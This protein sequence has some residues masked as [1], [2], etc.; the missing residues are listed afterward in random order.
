M[1]RHVA[2]HPRPR[3]LLALLL[4]KLLELRLM[5]RRE[6]WRL[7][8]LHARLLSRLPQRLLGLL[9]IALDHLR[10]LQKLLVLPA[11]LSA[12]LALTIR[13][14]C[15]LTCALGG[16]IN[17]PLHLGG[18]PGRLCARLPEPLLGE[19]GGLNLELIVAGGMLKPLLRHLL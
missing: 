11:G 12:R 15:L 19:L 5:D 9:M 2:E 13:L 17:G 14:L 4:L 8:D 3:E 7:A 1:S 6:L 10:G 18:S 16:V